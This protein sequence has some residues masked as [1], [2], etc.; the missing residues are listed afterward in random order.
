MSAPARYAIEQK[1]GLKMGGIEPWTKTDHGWG[2]AE[3]EWIEATF[4][5]EDEHTGSTDL[6]GNGVLGCNTIQMAR[7]GPSS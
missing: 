4:K 6:R 5:Y 3:R 1:P 7:Y 2:R